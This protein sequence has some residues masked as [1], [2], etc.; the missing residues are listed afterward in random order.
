MRETEVGDVCPIGGMREGGVLVEGGEMASD[1]TNLLYLC[2][3]DTEIF[4]R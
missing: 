1:L 2:Q 3:P 4:H